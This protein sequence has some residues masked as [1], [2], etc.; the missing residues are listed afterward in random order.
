MSSRL[1]SAG[2]DCYGRDRPVAVEANGIKMF[3]RSMFEEARSRTRDV[4]SPVEAA[5]ANSLGP[6]GKDGNRLAKPHMALPVNRTLARK[7]LLHRHFPSI[8]RH[9][10][11][12][13]VLAILGTRSVV[14]SGRQAVKPFSPALGAD[15]QDE[16]VSISHTTRALKVE[17][18]CVSSFRQNIESSLSAGLKMKSLQMSLPESAKL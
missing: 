1:D 15:E 6:C 8:Y 14:T 3:P 10:S 12:S 13:Q 4:E 9:P 16:D 11:T 18:V 7:C 17:K 5:R 2:S